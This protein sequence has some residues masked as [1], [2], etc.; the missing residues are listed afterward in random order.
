MMFEFGNEDHG[1]FLFSN[2]VET[3]GRNDESKLSRV[4]LRVRVDTEAIPDIGG[5]SD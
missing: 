2:S 1:A 5:L 3:Y 4:K